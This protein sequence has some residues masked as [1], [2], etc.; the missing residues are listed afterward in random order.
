MVRTSLIAFCCVAAV[1]A[2]LAQGK[3][4]YTAAEMSALLGK[5][6]A[7]NTASTS[8]DLVGRAKR[9]PRAA[10]RSVPA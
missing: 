8:G 6:L 4:P 5:G 10:R 3:T 1:G 9:E 2:A 7:V